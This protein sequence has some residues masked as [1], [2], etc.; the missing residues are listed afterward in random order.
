MR[1]VVLE[2]NAQVHQ[3][4]VRLHAA[5]LEREV[6]L[7]LLLHV[8]AHANHV[9]AGNLRRAFEE[10]NPVDELLRVLHLAHRLLVVLARELHEAPVLA[11][12]RLAEVLIDR[13]QLDGE[14]AVEGFDHVGVALHCGTPEV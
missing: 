12:L 11:H 3:L 1:V 10:Q 7:E 5:H 4:V 8:G 2:L 14:R 9:V 6:V 13:G